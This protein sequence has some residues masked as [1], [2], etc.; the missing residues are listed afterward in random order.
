MLKE[1][2]IPLVSVKTIA[3]VI[4]QQNSTLIHSSFDNLR[5]R[6]GYDKKPD[7][8]P[9][10]KYMTTKSPN[11]SQMNKKH[12][13]RHHAHKD[14]KESPAKVDRQPKEVDHSI[15]SKDRDSLTAASSTGQPG[16]IQRDD[17]S[18]SDKRGISTETGTSFVETSFRAPADDDFTGHVMDPQDDSDDEIGINLKRS[19][20][21]SSVKH[22]VELESENDDKSPERKS[23]ESHKRK[24]IEQPR[25]ERV[26][27]QRRVLS[28]TTGW[29]EVAPKESSKRRALVRSPDEIREMA[30]FEEVL[31]RANTKTIS[32][33]IGPPR[34]QSQARLRSIPT[35]AYIP[36]YRAFRKNSV[37]QASAIGNA[38]P[39]N[40]SQGSYRLRV[41]RPKESAAEHYEF[42]E[43]RRALEEQQRRAEALFRDSG[44]RTAKGR[45]RQ[46]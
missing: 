35:S 40:N 19:K 6:A 7:L 38:G 2:Q 36:D 20:E 3:Q 8:P 32:G 9:H 18:F 46:Q 34:G 27:K 15:I 23:A 13:E 14:T 33:M 1:H 30:G 39:S 25:I 22:R 10:N 37:P 44:A 29:L 45:R 17:L 26:A 21:T 31:P 41:H 42:E 5:S 28:D 12:G 16:Q 24:E 43:Q 4:A 11:E